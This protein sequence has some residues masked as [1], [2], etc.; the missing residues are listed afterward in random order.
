MCGVSLPLC[1]ELT[2]HSRPAYACVC[3]R[4]GVCV[5]VCLSLF[6][7]N[8]LYTRAL[9]RQV[10][11]KLGILWKSRKETQDGGGGGGG[12]DEGIG[13]RGGEGSRG[14]GDVIGDEDDVCAGLGALSVADPFAF[15]E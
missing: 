10:M 14:G 5:C 2:A 11:N 9:S 13:A 1:H 8:S 6:L 4:I 7:T 3:V 15:D 12:L